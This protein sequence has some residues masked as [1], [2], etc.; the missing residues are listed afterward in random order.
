MPSRIIRTC[1]K[2]LSV[3]REGFQILIDLIDGIQDV[4]PIL[5]N[6]KTIIMIKTVLLS[7]I[8][9]LSFQS[10]VNAQNAALSFNGS[11]DYIEIT[12]ADQLNFASNFTIEAWVQLDKTNGTNF[13]LSKS[14]CGNSEYAYTFNVVDGKVRWGWNNN[15]NCNFSSMVETTNIIY[16]PGDCHH[17]AVS[18]SSSMV[19][20]YVDG[21]EV[22][23]ALMLGNYSNIAPSTEPFR[24]G[25]YKGL[26]GN[27]LYF[28]DGK[29]DEL[30][31]WNTIR[32]PQQVAFSMNNALL[33]NESNLVLYF[34]FE[35]LIA[36]SFITI[37]NKANSTGASLNGQSSATSPLIEQSCAVINNLN[38]S[39][40]ALS[41]EAVAHV[42]PNPTN[43]QLTIQLND[44]H[45]KVAC[46]LYDVQGNLIMMKRCDAANTN[47]DISTLAN[48]VYYLNIGTQVVKVVKH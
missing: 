10:V 25:I 19:K 5:T 9:L 42:F 35:N 37:P 18:H 2:F 38:V 13:I 43:G 31:I 1:S 28:M 41:P 34:D 36:G 40:N 29:I 26:N 21:V 17:L 16:N 48:G 7:S 27:F 11:A 23:T 22:P 33:G 20:I 6:L 30:K 8:F 45:S 24:L 32:T 15:G 3:S 46:S 14:W 39:E 4:K 12:N 44:P 47:L